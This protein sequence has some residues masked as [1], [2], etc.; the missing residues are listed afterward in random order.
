MCRAV[1][2]APTCE[3]DD[4]IRSE[5]HSITTQVVG[6]E[7]LAE[8]AIAVLDVARLS[9]GFRLRTSATRL[10]LRRQPLQLGQ[11]VYRPVLADVALPRVA[12]PALAQ[13]A[14]HAVL[15]GRVDLVL[16]EA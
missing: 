1:V 9:S 6:S 2:R 13:A 8:Q 7:R 5:L 4:H 16:P 3:I 15:Q 11:R 12:P 10:V 14:L